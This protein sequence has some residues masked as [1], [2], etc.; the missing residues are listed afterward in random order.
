[1][2]DTN[3][4][5]IENLRIISKEILNNNHIYI[6]LQAQKPY[7]EVFPGQFVQ[8]EIKNNPNVFLRRPIS[9]YDWN[10]E[11]GI[12]SL[13]IKIVGKGTRTLSEINIGEELSLIYPLGNGF[14][15]PSEKTALLVGGGCGSAPLLY[16][17]RFLSKKKIKLDII[18]GA[19][20]KNEIIH[21]EKYSDFGNVHFMT[22]D[23]SLGN[24]G[25]VTD[26]P[27]LKNEINK[28]KQIYTCGP[29]PMMKAIGNIALEKNIPCEVSLENMMACGIGACLCC[30]VKS[31]K[32]NIC[33]CTEGPVFNI[34]FLKQWLKE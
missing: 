17:A 27:L 34:N 18:I 29:N 14:S 7:P 24:K 30:V 6:E 4:K 15:M 2:C 19:Y 8:I 11:K 33:T 21:P 32:G 23:N 22:E 5:K 1:M 26:H 3:K 9:V 20:T 16:L 28:V 31:D 25:L 10:Q 13:W 12:L